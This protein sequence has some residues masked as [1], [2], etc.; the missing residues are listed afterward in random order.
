MTP[1]FGMYEINSLEDAVFTID[2][3]EYLKDSNNLTDRKKIYESLVWAEQNPN[4]NFKSLMDNAPVVKEFA[5]SNEEIY[6]YL[7]LFKNFMEDESYELLTDDR[8]TIEL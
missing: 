5:F 6:S 8:P 3:S 1:I 2:S 7:L 4:Y